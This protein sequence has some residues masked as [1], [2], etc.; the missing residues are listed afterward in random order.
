VADETDH[1][2]FL[3]IPWVET[4]LETFGDAVDPAMLAVRAGDRVVA[5]GMLVRS[6]PSLSRPFRR[7]SFN[8]SGENTADTTYVEFNDVLARPGWETQA[9]E[10]LAAYALRQQWEELTLDGFRPGLAYES[11]KGAFTGMQLEEVRKPSY[12]VDL[13][14]LRATGSRYLSALSSRHRKHLQQNLRY[15]AERGA[16]V[17]QAAPS[18]AAALDM[19][20]EMAALNRR[21]RDTLGQPS[22]FSSERFTAF[23]RSFI[24]KTF[25]LGRVQ[26]LRVL[27]GSA[28]VG[29]VYNLVHKGKVYFY[30]CGFNYAAD[31]RLSPGIVSLALVIQY[32]IEE[33]FLE[34][35]FLAGAASYKAS[36]S[37]GSR[38]LIWATFRRPG[39]RVWAYGI[40]R[41]L[42][43]KFRSHSGSTQA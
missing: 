26:M 27:A 12:F 6:G 4:W 1:S 8:A 13:A 39:A 42:K 18:T 32:C 11:I 34:F 37:T 31:R 36:M 43:N 25:P 9:G 20:E 38:P 17:L 19:F 7:L 23:H 3:T 35:D 14:A 30:Q 28:T 29:L 41:D 5:A 10:A 40:A 24:R 15:H 16:V 2:I 21:R 33:G 22:V